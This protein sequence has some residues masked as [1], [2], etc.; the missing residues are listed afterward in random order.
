MRFQMAR[1]LAGHDK[2]KLYIV[3]AEEDGLL[4]LCDGRLRPLSKPKQKKR[5]HV[6]PITHIPPDI[7]KLTEGCDEWDDALIRKVIAGYNNLLT[8]NSGL[9]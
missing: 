4:S 1:S 6:Q 2:D 8:V 3:T 5:K 9:T 7:E